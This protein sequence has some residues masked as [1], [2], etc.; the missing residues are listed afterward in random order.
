[1]KKAML[2]TFEITTRVIV[3]A[4]Y[5]NAMNA[6]LDWEMAKIAADRIKANPD[7]YINAENLMNVSTDLEDPYDPDYDKVDLHIPSTQEMID[8]F[9]KTNPKWNTNS[10]RGA[11]ISLPTE[12]L[13]MENPIELNKNTWIDSIKIINGKQVKVHYDDPALENIGI[14]LVDWND[15]ST[16]IKLKILK[17]INYHEN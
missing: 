16:E 17:A 11:A 7:G 14:S 12:T 8:F 1:M 2:L 5:D 10:V 15:I 13:L 3:D 4:D 6:N 9:I